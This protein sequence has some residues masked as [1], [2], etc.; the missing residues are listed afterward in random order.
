MVCIYFGRDEYK[1]PLNSIIAGLGHEFLSE[2]GEDRVDE[3]LKENV[4]PLIFIIDEKL[5]K[6]NDI[7]HHIISMKFSLLKYVYIFALI[8]NFN[9]EKYIKFLNMGIDNFFTLP[10]SEEEL[11][12]KLEYVDKKFE[13]CATSSNFYQYFFKDHL[14]P[15]IIFDKEGIIKDVNRSA[16]LLFHQNEDY[17]TGRNI[18]NTFLGDQNKLINEYWK[19]IIEKQRRRFYFKYLLGVKK[20]YLD[21][22]VGNIILNKKEYFLAVINDITQLKEIEIELKNAYNENEIIINSIH[23]IFIHIDNDCIVKRWNKEAEEAFN[24]PKNKA[25]GEKIDKLQIEWDIKAL[26]STIKS[27]KD[28]SKHL[29]DINFIDPEGNVRILALTIYPMSKNGQIIGH[30]LL[31]KDITEKKVM[32]SQLVHAQ[33][34]EAIGELAAGI[35]HEINT[36]VQYVYGNLSYIKDTFLNLLELIGLYRNVLESLDREE[37]EVNE[38]LD[39]VRR[40]EEEMDVDFL[41]EDLPNAL[42]ESIQGLERVIEI[43]RSMRDFAH[44]GSQEKKLFDVNKAIKDTINISR[45]V[46]KYHSEIKLELDENLP[47]VI[48]YGDEINQVILNI[49]VNAAHAITEKV[50]KSKS[51]EKGLITIKTCKKDN[52]VEIQ[53]KDTGCG[54]PKKI[55]DK[56][57][58]PFF[59]TKEVGKGTGQ[60]LYLAFNIVKK[61]NGNLF[62]ESEEGVG[63]T[64]YI[65]LPIAKEDTSSEF[66]I[67]DLI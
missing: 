52:M 53:I 42:D 58:D 38:L 8:E 48:G 26:I 3:Y 37:I 67:G 44:S 9:L 54:I 6:F 32:E 17:F 51:D 5:P 43:V 63:T 40:K 19:A 12:V 15:M 22:Q 20:K 21:I 16:C 27:V 1:V 56:I 29:S 62:F 36:P 46:W 2:V 18:L 60:G 61:H 11:Y 10:L 47:P 66:E 57:F 35:A 39:S 64:F 33:K 7:I 30:L 25:I 14:Q 45:N 24:I 31:G 4:S 55:R 23:S 34:L 59:T 50:T 41:K 28:Q 49:I 13:L 65:R